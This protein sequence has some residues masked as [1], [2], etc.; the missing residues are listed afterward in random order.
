MASVTR[1]TELATWIDQSLDYLTGDWKAIPEIAAD[2]DNRDELERL[3][4]VVEWPLRE[5]RLLQLKQWHQEGLL[6][7]PQRER[8]DE[9]RWLIQHHRA[10]LERVLAD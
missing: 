7:P 1:H 3:D 9:L 6:T 10:T 8:F 5:D 2:W 4:F